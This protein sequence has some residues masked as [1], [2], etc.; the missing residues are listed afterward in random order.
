MTHEALR[1][2]EPIPQRPGLPLVGSA[3]DLPRDS[4]PLFH[5]M[6]EAKELGPL[7]KFSVFGHEINFASGLDLVTELADETRFRKN[8]HD[9]LVTLR[10]LAGD[11]LI[12]A[13]ND[14]PNWRKAHDV[15][16]PSFSLGAMRGYHATMLKVARELIGKWDQA[17]GTEPV[18][19]GDDMTRLT[20][21]TIG[22]CGFGYD[23]ESFSRKE[24]H[25]FVTSLSRVLGFVQEKEDS[26]PG[27]ELFKW[28]KT[29]RFREDTTSMK[30]LVDDVIR[31][32]KA[33]G[34]RSTDDILGRML[35]TRDAVT[36]E[37]LDDVN[38]RYQA[39]TFLIAGHETTSGALSFALYYLTKHPEILARAQAEVDA[40][41]GDSD[42]P[43]PDYG[44]IGKLTYIRQVLN[45][46][47]RLWPT[48]PA[49]GVEALE[50]TVIGGKYVLRKGEAVEVLIP[51]LHRDPAWGENV[52]L[53]DPDRFLPEREEA[54]PV[55]LFKPF[56][57]GE[58]ACI[59]RQFALH[60]ATLV[61]ALLVHR[62]RL[63]DHTDYQL[64]ISQS[65]TIK[66][67]GFTLNLAR[68]TSDERRLPTATEDV[69]VAAA[70]RPATGRAT[71]TA[72]TLLHGSNLGTCAGIAHDLASDGDA[73][74]FTPSVAPLDDAV[75][76]LS[77]ADGPVVIVAA[78][79]NGRPTDDA[80]RFITWLEGLEPGALDGLTYAVLGVGDRNWAA[81]Y[82]RIPT[83]IDERLTAAGATPLL[84][85][86][87]ADASGDFAGTV[88]RWTGDLWT[89]LLERYG[90]PGE[91]AGTEPDAGR[92]TGL[93][94]LEDATDSVTGALA[95][96]HGVQPMEVLDAYELVDMN[97]QLGRSKRFLKLRLPDGVTYRTGDHIA[98]LPSNPA[99]LVQRVADRFSLD[100]DRTVRLRARR[101]SRSALP[102]DRPLTLRRL[103]T[104]FVE[105]Q[106][107]A[108]RE[109]A[110]ALAGH[111]ACP[112]EKR[113]LAELAE[114]DAE[115]F[116]EQVTA[117]GHSLLDLLERYRACE[118][119]FEVF[120]E[121]LPVLR[122][123]H[124]SISSSAKTSP[125][126]A[127]LMVSL[128]AAPH[129]GGEGTFRGIGSHHL[130]TVN[131]GD[132]VQ[133]RVLPCSDAFRL[134]EDDSAPAILV[135]AGTGLAPFRGAVLDRHHAKST[136]T[137]LCYFGCDH[138]DVDYLHRAEF[139]AA[140]AAGAVSM[141]P[142]F[143]CAPEDGARFVQDRIAKESDEVW[144]A[145]EAGSRVYVCG[146]GRRMA[147]AVREAFMAVYRTHTG[148]DDEEATAWLAALTESGHYVED[149]W[150]G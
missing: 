57:N 48:A 46:A 35:H 58:R 132:T 79:Y 117:A 81:T 104:D 14:E 37:P 80:A 127:D 12:T 128:L 89:T 17:V 150:A 41:W 7:F 55:H 84:E 23:F 34:D 131:A 51:Q 92:E 140:E 77:D 121:L 115:T 75:G 29:E 101:R 18:D 139:E 116:R 59:G 3:F 21:D 133:A 141:R 24:P 120:L 114:A 73:R 94:A 16:M 26:I 31:Q 113:P 66:P 86:T 68:R 123:R 130:Q 67:D 124:Y 27:T 106:D 5:V 28:K 97:H 72:L 62:Y 36:G 2:T 42:A 40:V 38:I 138:P 19:V 52:E 69:A 10:G 60:E 136:G 134:P 56:G 6:K 76:K 111:T 22:L 142:T 147:P 83:L 100:L 63:I 39:I 149:V 122:P 129:R 91:D 135:S 61:L 102:V 105:L 8:V 90:T 82:Q 15:L 99:D 95:A 32:R 71:G 96:R 146:D 53:F 112:P 20:L 50:D 1:G 78:S 109:Q 54:R 4:I 103:L 44:D 85:R 33:S 49:Y 13:Y 88:D 148:A 47:L 145:L 144:A 108:T 87:A 9:V 64:K 65:V 126:E 43:D 119:P 45:E 70:H 143:S 11:G 30:D 125:G 137:L 110:A 107:P 98:V 25:P 74:G 93:Y 118:L